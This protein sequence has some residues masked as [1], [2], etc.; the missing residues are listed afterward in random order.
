MSKDVNLNDLE[1]QQNFND[2]MRRAASQQQLSFFCK[3]PQ[4]TPP[5]GS[6]ASIGY[7]GQGDNVMSH[8][9]CHL[10][11]C[12]IIDLRT[13]A[14]HDLFSIAYHHNMFCGFQWLFKSDV[15]YYSVGSF[16]PASTST[17][18]CKTPLRKVC[19]VNHKQQIQDDSNV[20]LN[21]LRITS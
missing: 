20:I 6:S 3:L 21:Y 1:R 5:H 12:A 10:Q 19:K 11:Q 8:C 15:S 14:S 7:H 13:V 16:R 18:E 9:C 17:T 4:A 2:T